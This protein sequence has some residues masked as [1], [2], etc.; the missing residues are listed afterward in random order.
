MERIRFIGSMNS[1]SNWSKISP[2]L[3]DWV[4][5][6]R[7][8]TITTIAVAPT[9]SSV[10]YVGTDDAHVWVSSNNGADW[11]EISVGLPERWVT[12]VIVDPKDENIIY[13]TFSGLK[14]FDPQPHVY[15]S[16]N[17]GAEWTDIS[18]NLPDAPVNAFAVDYKYSNVLY[19]GNDVGMYVSFN[20]GQSW[21]VLGERLPVLPIGDIKIHPSE[22]FLVAG[23]HGRSM[24]KIDLNLVTSTVNEQPQIASGFNLSQNY[25]NPFNPITHIQFTI[26]NREHVKLRVYDILGNE[27]ANLVDEEKPAGTY[28]I[29]FNSA[30][31]NRG[32]ALP[33]GIYLYKLSV[34]DYSETKKMVI[35]K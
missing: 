15:R 26:S 35:L 31:H 11:T 5:E 22:Y 25:P 28:E 30:D 14:W 20:A 1:A 6:S 27:I 21:E 29:E 12:R 10:I 19:L 18:S 4:Q 34:G 16:T 33:S 32:V 8:G 24:Y 3:T 2:Q 9:N 7:L 17:K 23:T 13:V